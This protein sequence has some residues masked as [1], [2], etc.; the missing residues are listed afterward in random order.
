MQ[1]K[2]YMIHKSQ[3]YL[4]M[5]SWCPKSGMDLQEVITHHL[6]HLQP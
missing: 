6:S 5:E 2:V 3:E 1:K 4:F